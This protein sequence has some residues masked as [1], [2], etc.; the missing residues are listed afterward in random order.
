MFGVIRPRNNCIL[1][2]I[3][4]TKVAGSAR[5]AAA[6]GL[7]MADRVTGEVTDN[8]AVKEDTGQHAGD[9]ADGHAMK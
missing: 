2:M 8:R 9:K 1:L 5:S 3:T 7:A 6:F 4:S